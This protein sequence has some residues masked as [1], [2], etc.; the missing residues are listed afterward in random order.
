MFMIAEWVANVTPT[1][2]RELTATSPF[3]PQNK[4]KSSRIW[5]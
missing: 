2:G 1:F 5:N 3:F 4:S